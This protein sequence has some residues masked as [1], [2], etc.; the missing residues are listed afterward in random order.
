[1]SDEPNLCECGWAPAYEELWGMVRLV[2]R[3]CGN[4]TGYTYTREDAQ[5]RW[6]EGLVAHYNEMLEEMG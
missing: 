1:M 5:R 4:N 6:D 3:H 2:C